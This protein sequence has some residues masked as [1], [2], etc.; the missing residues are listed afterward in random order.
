L[1]SNYEALAEFYSR[2]GFDVQPEHRSWRLLQ[3][4]QSLPL[5]QELEQVE[6]HLKELFSVRKN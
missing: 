4:Q 3:W 6:A 1:R 5:Y 2:C